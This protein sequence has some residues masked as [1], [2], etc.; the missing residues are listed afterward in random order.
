[1]GRTLVDAQNQFTGS[2]TDGWYPWSSNLDEACRTDW[3][4]LRGEADT[5]DYSTPVCRLVWF[6]YTTD[7]NLCDPI[8]GCRFI[9]IMHVKRSDLEAPPEENPV[10]I[11]ATD[12]A[13][14]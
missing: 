13:Q 7:R 5:C 12:W 11:C 14:G 9:C 3:A 2:A 6:F 1:V 4:R 8:R 10:P